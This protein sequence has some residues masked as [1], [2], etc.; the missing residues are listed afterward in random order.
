MAGGVGGPVLTGRADDDLPPVR[1]EQ[2]GDVGRSEEQVWG[3][4]RGIVTRS[5]GWWPTMSK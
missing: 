1:A 5:E 3:S 4:G 2:G